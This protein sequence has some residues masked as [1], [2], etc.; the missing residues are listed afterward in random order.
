MP[1]RTWKITVYRKYLIKGEE[2]EL[3]YLEIEQGWLP[4]DVDAYAWELG[5]CRGE[6]TETT[7]VEVT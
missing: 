1:C 4:E 2:Q 6:I 5:G 7:P 3:K